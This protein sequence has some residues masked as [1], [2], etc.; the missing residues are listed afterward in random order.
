[1]K[2]T[3]NIRGSGLLEWVCEHGVGHPDFESAKLVAKSYGHPVG[4]W[5]VHGCDGCCNREDFP[6][7]KKIK[8]K[9]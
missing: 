4:T 9:K 3:K 8:E 2:W 1:M 7:N 6:G 5:L